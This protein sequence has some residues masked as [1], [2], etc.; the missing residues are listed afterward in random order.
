MASF[1]QPSKYFTRF[2][3]IFPENESWTLESVKQEM[4]DALIIKGIRKK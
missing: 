1:M 3:R 2:F 4:K